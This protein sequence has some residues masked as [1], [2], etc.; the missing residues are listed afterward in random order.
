MLDRTL[1]VNAP[2]SGGGGG[3]CEAGLCDSGCAWSFDECRCVGPGCESPILV[4]VSGDG[5]ALTD[6]KGGV[7]F[8]IDA[9]ATRD[10]IAWTVE[11]SDDAFL[12]LDR[13]GNGRIEDGG[14]LFGNFTPQPPSPGRNGF[15]AL[16]EFDSTM[17]GGNGDGKIDDKDSVFASLRL[18]RDANHNGTSEEGELHTLPSL[19]LA[20]IDLGYKEARRRDRHGNLFR[21]RAKVYDARG[22]SL[23]RWAW[24]VFLV[25]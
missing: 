25:H 2:A 4:D 1:T 24:D 22:S 16:A 12:A 11:N 18:W 20:G 3:E 13:D 19:G 9:N 17:N 5:F 21:Y 15:L 10:R 7:Y 8:D 6:G 14:E 23:G